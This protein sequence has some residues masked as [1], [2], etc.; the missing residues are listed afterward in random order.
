MLVPQNI[1]H[2]SATPSSLSIGRT[3]YEKTMA[4]G[5]FHKVGVR[6]RNLIVEMTPALV[7]EEKQAI[8]MCLDRYEY[9][10]AL[11]TL[12]QMLENKQQPLSASTHDTLLD[13]GW[14]L[15]YDLCELEQ[16]LEAML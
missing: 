14:C 8:H 4:R 1:P 9:K 11:D 15:C 6:M 3:D 5:R 10:L 7:R 2:R 12:L 13:L 16:R